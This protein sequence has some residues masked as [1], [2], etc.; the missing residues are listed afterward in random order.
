MGS[1]S[2]TPSETIS[3]VVVDAVV[4]WMLRT[5]QLPQGKAG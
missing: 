4:A 3:W 1:S 5:V 2:L